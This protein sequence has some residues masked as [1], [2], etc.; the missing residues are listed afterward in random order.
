MPRYSCC[1]R[2]GCKE[3]CHKKWACCKEEWNISLGDQR[4]CSSRY[5]CCGASTTQSTGGC[6]PRYNC[7]WGE[8]T[9]Q[10]CR[11]VCRKCAEDWGTQTEDCF[12]KEHELIEIGVEEVV[13]ESDS[14]YDDESEDDESDVLVIRDKFVRKDKKLTKLFEILGRFPP[15]ITYHVV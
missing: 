1:G 6:S 2:R 7:C 11:K 9:D 13:D 15:I 5:K 8:V 4:G 14:D 12:R 3:G 10:G